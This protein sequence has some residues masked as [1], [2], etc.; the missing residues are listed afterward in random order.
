MRNRSKDNLPVFLRP[1]MFFPLRNQ[2]DL[3]RRPL[4]SLTLPFFIFTIA[5]K[6]DIVLAAPAFAG[7]KTGNIP[8]KKGTLKLSFHSSG[9]YPKTAK[10]NA[11]SGTG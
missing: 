1:M 5:L 2:K 11:A 3:F 8:S 10:R 7:L 9:I 6:S 4:K